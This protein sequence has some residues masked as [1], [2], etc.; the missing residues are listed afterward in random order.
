MFGSLKISKT[1]PFCIVLYF[2]RLKGLD[3]EK[4]ILELTLR[5][6]SDSLKMKRTELSLSLDSLNSL[7]SDKLVFRRERVS[8]SLG[9]LKH[10][11]G[12]ARRAGYRT[13]ICY[14]P[15]A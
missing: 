4:G 9:S 14:P 7:N 5:T 3:D 6:F 12:L 11:D 1:H 13:S 10:S 8:L 2:F 15:Q